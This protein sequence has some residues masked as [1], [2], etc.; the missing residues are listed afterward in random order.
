MYLAIL[1]TIC[2]VRITKMTAD[3]NLLVPSN[4]KKLTRCMMDAEYGSNR[5]LSVAW[6][7][8]LILD[9]A[10]DSDYYSRLIHY[11]QADNHGAILIAEA[12]DGHLCGFADVGASL[13]LPNDRCF[14][15]PQS[16]D[17]KRL[18]ATGLGTDGL[19]KPGVELRPYVSNLVVDASRRRLGIG[20]K[21]MEACEAEA[22]SWAAHCRIADGEPA[23]AIWLEVT[24]TNERALSFYHTLGYVDDGSSTGTEV[25]Q[26]EGGFRLVDVK[27][28]VLR[29]PLRLRGGS[30]QALR[31][32]G[33]SQQ[34]PPPWRFPAARV[35]Y[36]PT[37]VPLDVARAA[38]P[39]GEGLT[40][41]SAC[42]YSLGGVC[43]LRLSTHAPCEDCERRSRAVSDRTCS[44]S[45][46]QLC[47]RLD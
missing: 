39:A 1:A 36:Q 3:S 32:R 34:P 15:L 14:R 17:L 23:E 40:I 33:G 7:Q 27:R 28:H 9:A 2:G 21:L 45:R 11:Q 13:W 46:P 25:V 18:A 35:L 12:E 29:R 43:V 24:V 38:T 8:R 30:Q 10:A 16:P 31:L 6:A 37:F 44:R 5:P 4:A 42:G 22:A 41:L 26:H 47:G 19:P 20:R